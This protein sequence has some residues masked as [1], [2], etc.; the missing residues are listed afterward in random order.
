M[1]VKVFTNLCKLKVSNNLPTRN[2]LRAFTNEKFL[3]NSQERNQNRIN[4]FK[5]KENDEMTRK[6]KKKV[7]SQ[8]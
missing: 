2:F 7:I 5:N 3:F 4:Q 8:N 1:F 6:L